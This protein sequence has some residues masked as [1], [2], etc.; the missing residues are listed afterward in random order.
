MSREAIHDR[1]RED[2]AN[3][4][5]AS[6]RD[7]PPR[8]RA[9]GGIGNLSQLTADLIAQGDLFPWSSGKPR[10]LGSVRV[11]WMRGR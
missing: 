6:C 10:A 5:P 2:F 7:I 4:G 1:L 11:R 8:P 9:L 3:L